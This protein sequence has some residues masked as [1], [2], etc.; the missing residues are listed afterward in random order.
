MITT[1]D[2][3]PIGEKALRLGAGWGREEEESERERDRKR[4]DLRPVLLLVPFLM[5]LLFK[6]DINKKQPP[7]PPPLN[8]PQPHTLQVQGN[9]LF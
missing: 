8:A 5:C 1:H 4:E 6:N 7:P 2:P 3:L 9:S